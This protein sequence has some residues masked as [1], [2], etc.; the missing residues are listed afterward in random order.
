MK[1]LESVVTDDGVL[2]VV[3]RDNM[4]ALRNGDTGYSCIYTDDT[5]Y[6]PILIP[7][8][9]LLE[10]F[11]LFHEIK[12]VA[13]LGGGCCTLPRFIIKRFNNTIRIDSIE[14]LS[15][16]VKL[17]HKHFLKDLDID[18]LKVITDDAFIFIR[19]TN[20]KYDFILVDLFVG[21]D[22]IK[23]SHSI[24]FLTDVDDHLSDGGI[25]VF[26]EYKRTIE[27]CKDFCKLGAAL[28]QKSFIMVDED[29]SYYVAFTNGGFDE[30]EIQNY[31]L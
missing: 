31:L 12:D 20:Q 9:K 8:Q 4:L 22:V 13:V 21:G 30:Q 24:D 7:V 5:V 11:S 18:K 26:N 10:R 27:E 3:S 2:S 17:T 29:N 16:I 14:Y 23:K 28:F 1:I 25:V 15:A 6:Q 19:K